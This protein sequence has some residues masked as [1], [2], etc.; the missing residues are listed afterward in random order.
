MKQ[1]YKSVLVQLVL[2]DDLGV[3]LT[4]GNKAIACGDEKTWVGQ[5]AGRKKN[6]CFVSINEA[7]AWLIKS[8]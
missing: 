8:Q 1:T 2:H 5:K 7:V 4:V 3:A 6:K